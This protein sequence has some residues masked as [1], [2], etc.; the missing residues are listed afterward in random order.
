[1]PLVVYTGMPQTSPFERMDSVA[2]QPRSSR[3]LVSRLR[4][5]GIMPSLFGPPLFYFSICVF[6]TAFPVSVLALCFSSLV[7]SFSV[8]LIIV[9]IV[10]SYCPQPLAGLAVFFP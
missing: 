3:S 4:G 6:R 5:R 9:F 7:T 10:L 8:D 1:M 2:I